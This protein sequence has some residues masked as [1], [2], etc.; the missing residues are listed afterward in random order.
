MKKRT[1]PYKTRRTWLALKKL[2][3]QREAAFLRGQMTQVRALDEEIS[4][5]VKRIVA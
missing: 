5:I 3:Q 1:E 4:L 2:H